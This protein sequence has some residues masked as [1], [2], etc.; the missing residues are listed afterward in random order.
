MQD[1]RNLLL[2][3]VLSMAVLLGWNYFFGVPAVDKNKQA[4]VQTQITQGGVPTIVK[5]VIVPKTREQAMVGDRVQIETPRLKGSI[6]L[7]GAR[8]DDI[9]L[10]N[11]K[12]TIDPKSKNIVYLSPEGSPEAYFAD[13]HYITGQGATVAVFGKDKLWAQFGGKL[14]PQTPVN[15]VYTENGITITRTLS[16]DDGFMITYKD[17]I[18]NKTDKPL[19]IRPY[20]ALTRH[21]TPKTEGFYILHEGMIGVLGEKGLQ[22]V[23]YD[24]IAKDKVMKFSGKGG[25]LGIT[26]KYWAAVMLPDQSVNNDTSFLSD[27]KTFTTEFAGEAKD[28]AAGASTEFTQQLFVGAKEV[29]TID[30]YGKKLEGARFDLLID[31]G[32]FHFITKPL[33]WM[34]DYL[35][36]L[37]GNFGVAI[38]FVTFLIKALFFPLAQK[39]Y[40]SIVK[41]K[42]VQPEMELL[43]VKYKD[44]RA[45]QQSELMALYKKEQINPLAGCWPVLLQIPVF[46]ALYKVL[47]VTIEMRHAPFFGWIKDLSAPDPTSIFNLFGLLP[48]DPGSLPLIGTYLVLG[49]WPLI[50]GVT[51][52]VQMQMNPAPNDPVQ[53]TIFRWM[54]VMFTFMLASFPAGLVIYWSW[55]NSLSIMQQWLIMKKFGVKVELWSNLKAMFGK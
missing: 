25:W 44:D 22:E 39:S 26:D 40:A 16:V 54:P 50:M 52:W 29:K 33:F 18:Q 23:Q 24:K 41:M 19:A 13:R 43:K 4:Q 11:Y 49:I 20:G 6:N 10:V 30:A 42:K 5:P 15:L 34:I 3:I 9:S 51:M 17:V 47:F 36:S 1:N 48:F 31:W 8:I 37:V 46:F 35:Y 21:G 38:I 53:A 14:T 12:E 2:T 28:I 45:K 55:S 27:G 7:N 32:W